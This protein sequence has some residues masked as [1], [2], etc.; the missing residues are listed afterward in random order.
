[1]QTYE[2]WVYLKERPYPGQVPNKRLIAS[3]ATVEGGFLCVD[4]ADANEPLYAF[5]LSNVIYWTMKPI[6][7]EDDLDQDT[8]DE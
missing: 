7:Q 3:E 1:M 2:V 5:S 8:Q 6:I 4:T